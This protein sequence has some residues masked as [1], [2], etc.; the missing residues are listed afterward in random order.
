MSHSPPSSTFESWSSPSLTIVCPDLGRPALPTGVP[1]PELLPYLD[2]SASQ[3]AAAPPFSSS[4]A[5][6][7]PEVPSPAAVSPEFVATDLSVSLSSSTVSSPMQA[8]LHPLPECSQQQLAPT[9]HPMIT[10]SKSNI[11]KPLQKLNL[12]THL[13]QSAEVEPTTAVQALK[14][15]QWRQAMSE[16]CNALIKNGTW[17]LVRSTPSIN[18]IGCKWIFRIKRNS[19]GTVDRYKARLVAKGFNQRPGV[20]YFETF[21]PVIKP[22]TV[23]LVLSIATSQGWSLRQLD[24][25][26]AFLQGHLSE[27]V[28]MAQPPGFVDSDHPTHV[29]KL[30]KAIYGLKQA[31]RAWY[32]ELRQFLIVYGFKN[33]YADTSLFVFQTGGILLYLLI[34]VDDIILTGNSATHVNQF[35]DT[36]AHKF[37]LKDLG[38]LSYFLGVEVVPHKQGILLS[39]RRYIMDLL[40]RTKMTEAKPVQTPLPTSPPISLHSGTPLSDPT[41]YRTVVG[42]LQYLSLTRPDISYAVNKLSQFMHQPS[43]D[44]WELVKRVLR[45]LGGTLNDGILIHRD[46]PIT[47]HAFSDAD[48]AGNKDDYSSTGAYIV[49]LG[50]NPISWSS[51][52]QHTIARSSTEA[53]YRTV[54]STAA[55]LNWVCFLL[56]D[57]GL[58]LPTVPTIY[59]D[60]VGATQL[61]SNPIFHSRMK[62]VAIDFHFIR[63][64]VQSGSLRVTHVS[65][66]DQLADALTKPL[67]RAAFQNLKCK[68][69]LSNRDLS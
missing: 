17:E 46:S 19:D 32:H 10:R 65:S 5:A 40:T 26:N 16:E 12:H 28:Y 34:Y 23:R 54:A 20:D 7:L 64:Q 9:V 47:L 11:H 68:I 44:H 37:S 24:V 41:T 56:T 4:A 13:H 66:K 61:C 50:R 51:K 3:Q 8:T 29:C 18:V 59:C 1:P 2:S 55:E 67:P 14:D 43:S 53:E 62:H 30:N 6:P 25:N 57:L 52:K 69:G 15:P 48:W 45:Y 60:N 39:Q 27:E 38:P 22:T 63:D 36:L 58:T 33:S 21:S 42:S 31:P 49:Y 35:V